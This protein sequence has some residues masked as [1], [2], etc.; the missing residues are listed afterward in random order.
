MPLEHVLYIRVQCRT[1]AVRTLGDLM[2]CVNFSEFFIV[3]WACRGQQRSG[4]FTNPLPRWLTIRTAWWGHEHS[5]ACVL[6]WD[7]V[8][9][10]CRGEFESVCSDHSWSYCETDVNLHLRIITIIAT[11]FGWETFSCGSVAD[12]VLLCFFH[13]LLYFFSAHSFI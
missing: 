2:W 8:Q 3:I 10:S 11:L 1:H 9:W 7:I 5:D 13:L 6:C 4:L 12:F